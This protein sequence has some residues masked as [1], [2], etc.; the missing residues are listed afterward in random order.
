[1]LI[2]QV[3]AF[4]ENKPGRLVEILTL[5]G[6]GGIDLRA[7]SVAETTEFGILRML[8]D[9]PEDAVALLK[10]QGFRAN[11][12]EILGVAIPHVPGSSVAVLQVLSDAGINVEYTYAFVTPGAGDA[13]LFLRVENNTAAQA[14]LCAAGIS[15]SEV[16]MLY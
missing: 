11:K 10:A 12:T 2:D 4:I 1:M 13:L 14:A 7:Y 9:R 16:K 8:V 6:E 5:L 15:L 3:S